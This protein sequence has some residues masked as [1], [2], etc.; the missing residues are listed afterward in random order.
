MSVEIR[1]L[2][3]FIALC[4]EKSFTGAARRIM[5]SQSVVSRTIQQLEKYVGCELVNRNSASIHPNRM[6]DL[7]LAHARRAVAEFDR[8]LNAVGTAHRPLRL[9]YM[10]STLDERMLTT[11]RAWERQHPGFPISTHRTDDRLAGLTDGS[12]DLG[13]VRE[14]PPTPFQT[15]LLLRERLC[16]A[17]PAD[18]P[19]STRNTLRLRDLCR[20][21]VVFNTAS[22]TNLSDLWT[23]VGT[24]RDLLHVATYDDWFFGIATGKG[25]GLTPASTAGMSSLPAIVYVELEDAPTVALQLAWKPPGGHAALDAFVRHAV[26]AF[27]AS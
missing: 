24:P 20:E 17:V 26:D 8:T 3:A 6:G 5:V 1:H 25:I 21:T 9:G 2:R 15:R 23:S 4:E 11:V 18:H 7:V 12:V 19:F 13:L 14:P 16:V 27:G 22:D 10:W